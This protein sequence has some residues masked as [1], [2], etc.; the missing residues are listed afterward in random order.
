M[1]SLI[2]KRL[3]IQTRKIGNTKQARKKYKLTREGMKLVERMVEGI[4]SEF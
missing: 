1:D 3:V 2:A 4:D